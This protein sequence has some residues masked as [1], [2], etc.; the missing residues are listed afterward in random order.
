MR[1]SRKVQRH[2]KSKNKEV[3]YVV[4]TMSKFVRGAPAMK[5][6]GIGENHVKNHA[7]N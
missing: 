5:S 2:G 1:T 4:G 7:G 3:R 6:L